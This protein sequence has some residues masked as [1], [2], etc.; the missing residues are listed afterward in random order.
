MAGNVSR[1]RSKSH[2]W[3]LH[4]ASLGGGRAAGPAIA[5]DG[6]IF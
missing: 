1:I 5:W 6:D 4:E 2:D 3:S